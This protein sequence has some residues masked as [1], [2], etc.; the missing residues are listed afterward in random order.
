MGTEKIRALATK[1]RG[2]DIFDLWYLISQGARIDMNLIQKKLAHYADS[3]NKAFLLSRINE[4][5]EQD[6]SADLR[7]FIPINQRNKLTEQLKYVQSY[8]AERL[9]V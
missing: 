8:L 6:Y 2:R 4:F 3:Y 7:P 9:P 5:S 1:K